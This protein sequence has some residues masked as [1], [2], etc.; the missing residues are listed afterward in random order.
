MVRTQI[1]LTK[2]EHEHFKVEAKRTGLSM[3]EII[4]R[5]LDKYMEEKNGKKIE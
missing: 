4:R 3:A 5:I 1:C 2:Q